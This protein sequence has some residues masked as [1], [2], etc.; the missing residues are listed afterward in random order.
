MGRENFKHGFTIVELLI[1]IVVIAI[2]AAITIIAYNGIQNRANDVTVQSDMKQSYSRAQQFYT[3][4]ER[5]PSS[6]TELNQVLIASR[7]AYGGGTNFYL[8]CRADN[9]AIAIAGRSKSGN[10]F[11]YSSNGGAIP[12]T[13][14]SDSHTTICPAA[15][16]PTNSSGYTV[17]WIASGGDWASWFTPGA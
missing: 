14:W 8:V 10:A 15:G 7:K 9:G 13:N 4:N 5:L 17:N 16:I 11:A 12:I 1:V 3:I 6:G 2:L